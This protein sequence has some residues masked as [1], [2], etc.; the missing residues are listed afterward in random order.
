[1]ECWRRYGI[2]LPNWSARPCQNPTLLEVNGET[3]GSSRTRTLGH[4]FEA[5]AWLANHLNVRGR[6]LRAGEF[7]MTGSTVITYF[8]K[9]ASSQVLSGDS[10]FG[11]IKLLTNS[12]ALPP[13]LHLCQ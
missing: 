13:L 1:M 11:R 10:R 6:T 12:C 2:P 8:P 4:P 5:V 3:L 7:V 9:L